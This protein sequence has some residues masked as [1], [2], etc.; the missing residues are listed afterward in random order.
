MDPEP[1]RRLRELVDKAL[2]LHEYE[3]D[4]FLQE[5]CQ[6]AQLLSEAR[7]LLIHYCP[8]H[9]GNDDFF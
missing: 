1:Y 5:N 9:K 6:D 2:D 7:D 3:R 8:T 4:V